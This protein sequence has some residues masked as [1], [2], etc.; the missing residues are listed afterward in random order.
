MTAAFALVLSPVVPREEAEA[1]RERARSAE[2]DAARSYREGVEEMEEACKWAF[3]SFA[4]RLP[5][6]LARR[7]LREQLAARVGEWL[8]DHIVSR[9]T[10]EEV[11]RAL[12]ES[13]IATA[14]E[15]L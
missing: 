4:L 6:G 3:H 15:Y 5:D 13:F 9:T 7:M 1:A 14:G 11:P 10:D 8:A 2:A 12:A